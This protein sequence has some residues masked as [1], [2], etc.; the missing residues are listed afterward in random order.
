MRLGKL[1]PKQQGRVSAMRYDTEMQR[2][3]IYVMRQVH[4]VWVPLQIWNQLHYRE[5][6]GCFSAI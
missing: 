6:A 1:T 2:G 5:W 3:M 4:G